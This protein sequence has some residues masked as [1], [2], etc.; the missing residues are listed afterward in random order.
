M[1]ATIKIGLAL[2]CDIAGMVPVR[3]EELLLPTCPGLPDFA[4]YDE[5]LCSNGYLDVDD[6]VDEAG[7]D[8]TVRV[9][10]ERVHMEGH[11]KLLHTGGDTGRIHGA[12]YPRR[13]QPRV[14]PLIEIVTKTIEGTGAL[15]PRWVRR[16]SRNCASLVRSLNVSDVRMEQGS[17]RCDAN[18]SLMPRAQA[19]GARVD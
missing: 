12:D 6:V 11:R 10:I 5:P 1:E 15:S 4:G 14:F 9:E 7:R 3:A 13:L 17:L 18:V 2:N 19:N 16:T 8:R